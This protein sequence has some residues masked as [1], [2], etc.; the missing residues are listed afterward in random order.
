MKDHFILEN[1]L[2]S[3]SFPK[4]KKLKRISKSAV[5]KCRLSP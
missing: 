4:V 2:L 5:I 3:H 1:V